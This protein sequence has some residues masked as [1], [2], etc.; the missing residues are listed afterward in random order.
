MIPA[1]LKGRPLDGV[2]RTLVGV[3]WSEARKLIT[4]GKI[5]VA[6]ELV[7]EPESKVRV[8][9]KIALDMRAPK[10]RTRK[11]LEFEGELIVYIDPSVV[12]V[13]KPAGV[14]T[15]PFGD[16]EPGEQGMT[17][18]ALVRDL[19]ARR[20]K[21]RGR[22]PLGVV[23]RLDKATSGLIVF[24]RS[25]AAKKHLAQQLRA[26]TMHRR[27]LAIAHGVVRKKTVRSHLVA[28]RGDGLRGSVPEGRREGQLAITHIEPIEALHGATLV[29]CRL[30]TG[31]I[32]SGST[33]PRWG[34]R[35]WARM[36]TSAGFV[37]N[38]SQ[39][40]GRCCTRQSSASSIPRQVARCASK[41]RLR[42]ISKRRSR[43]CGAERLQLLGLLSASLIA[44]AVASTRGMTL[45]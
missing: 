45:A 12:V 42:R 29:A 43:V 10:P 31:R 40:R 37:A 2:V 27:Y 41:S 3:S 7:T 38:G 11:L 34:I 26:H 32:R 35:S 18:D 19:V 30:E 9:A 25:F 23:Q 15:V 22:A 24:A 8:G 33:C 6:G 13:R 20:D 39:R 1:E 17:L 14:S 5:R 16:E 21:I 4:T 28:N 36:C 44:A